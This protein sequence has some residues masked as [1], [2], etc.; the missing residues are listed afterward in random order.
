LG[1]TTVSID[2]LPAPLFYVGATQ[3]N[4][5]IPYEEAGKTKAHLVIQSSV[6]QSSELDIALVPASLGLF[7][8][9]GRQ[10]AALNQ[11]YS[12]NTPA[13]PV[14][15]GNVV[16]L[17]GTGQGPLDKRVATGAPGP[18][19]APF[20]EPMFPISMAVNGKPA[21]VLFAGTAPGLVGLLQL[22]LQIPED[23]ASGPAT[24]T[25]RQGDAAVAQSVVVYVQA[26]TAIPGTSPAQ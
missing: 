14:P 24:I 4:F 12:Y 21:K 16:M 8:T 11:D 1:G 7:T 2:G 23:T 22:N 9:D 10:A 25:F 5:Q 26:M 20:P 6:A 17:F 18:T 13:T 3:I 19:N 15:A